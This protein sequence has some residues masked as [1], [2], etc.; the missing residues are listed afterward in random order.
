M[1]T[2]RVLREILA[3]TP[4]WRANPRRKI[5]QG[6]PACHGFG[7]VGLACSLFILSAGPAQAQSPRRVDSL[8]DG[9]AEVE[10][11]VP[12]FGGMFIGADGMLR[13]YLVDMT[14]SANVETEIIDVFGRDRLPV[15]TV[16]VLQGTYSFVQ[17]KQWH[18]RHRLTT[19]GIPGVVSTGINEK[20]NRLKIGVLDKSVF[21]AVERSL[22]N[23]GIPR[24]AV[25]IVEVEPTL[26]YA[27]LQQLSRPLQ[28]GLQVSGPGGTCTLGFLA[29]RAGAAGFVTA[30]HCTI[31]QGG[32][33]GTV[34]H[35]PFISGTV[36]QIGI[37]SVD[38]PYSGGSRVSDSAFVQRNAG[39]NPLTPRPSADFG[40]IA[41][42][43]YNSLQIVSQF[44]I[45]K[46]VLFPI[47][48]KSLAKVGRTTGLTEGIVSETCVDTTQTTGFAILCQD[49][50]DAPSAPGDSGSPVFWSSGATLLAGGLPSAHLHGVLWGGNKS[51]TDFVFSNMANVQKDLGPLKTYPEDGG[52]NSPPEVKITAPTTGT[53]V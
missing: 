26:P 4:S 53:T 14:Q 23:L 31:V 13:V 40:Y 33:E 35:Q 9:F 7:F 30:S 22:S 8:H 2:F 42:P 39:P 41:M 3:F 6:V 45:A 16:H 50:V 27:S 36:N 12:G 38:P 5:L 25:T 28:G 29:V 49:R 11:R 48:G 10:K 20:T 51:G 32:T 21:P 52:V 24:Q 17:L 43:D 19:L 47:S 44:R 15:G 1:G 37:E 34:F 18:D 46:K